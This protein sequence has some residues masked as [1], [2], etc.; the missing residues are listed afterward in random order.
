ML[1]EKKTLVRQFSEGETSFKKKR[2][3]PKNI[4]IS[5]TL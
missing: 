1:N 3:G 2:F 5:K 4:N